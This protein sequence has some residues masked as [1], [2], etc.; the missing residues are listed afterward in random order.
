MSVLLS[1][2][3]VVH[4]DRLNCVCIT[5]MQAG[6]GGKGG[7]LAK[8]AMVGKTV[9]ITKGKNKGLIGICLD[10]TATHAKV[11]GEISLLNEQ[12]VKTDEYFVSTR[13]H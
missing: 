3:F 9:R 4:D 10:A 12:K 11:C 1:S 2:M 13:P 6:K 7:P 8:P 5:T